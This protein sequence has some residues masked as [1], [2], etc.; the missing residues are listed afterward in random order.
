MTSRNARNDK[1]RN[2]MQLVSERE[3]DKRETLPVKLDNVSDNR[4]YRDIIRL[5][6][7]YTRI[8]KTLQKTFGYSR[9]NTQIIL[10]NAMCAILNQVSG[11]SEDNKYYGR[12]AIRLLATVDYDHIGE[13]N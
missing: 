8:A 1:F 11:M 6:K 9:A 5:S 10:H 13:V 2:D 12:K 7:E 4:I 3:S